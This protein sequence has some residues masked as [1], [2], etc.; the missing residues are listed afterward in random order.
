MVVRRSTRHSTTNIRRSR[1][2]IKFHSTVILRQSRR[3]RVRN[4]IIFGIENLAVWLTAVVE[5]CHLSLLDDLS[6]DAA[7]L[8]GLSVR[9][10]LSLVRTST[11]A[12]AA[13]EGRRVGECSLPVPFMFVEALFADD[14]STGSVGEV[15]TRDDRKT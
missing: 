4:I 1:G 3:D 6:V 8:V 14:F 9:F 15:G 12:M 13:G 5:L 10:A 2:V 7:G 11:L